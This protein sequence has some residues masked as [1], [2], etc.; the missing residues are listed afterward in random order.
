M[1]SVGEGIW[2]SF[3][4]DWRGGVQKGPSPLLTATLK[5]GTASAR[6][7]SSA[8]S[9]PLTSLLGRFL[10][11]AAAFRYPQAAALLRCSQ[12][13]TSITGSGTKLDLFA[14]VDLNIYSETRLSIRKEA[15]DD[16][17]SALRIM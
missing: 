3:Q 2:L 7:D 5:T 14:Y 9:S 4:S 13:A 16:S 15:L 10:C 6:Y 12:D 1:S 11:V 8:T 17:E